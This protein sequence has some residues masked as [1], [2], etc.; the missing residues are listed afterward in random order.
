M[1]QLH[2]TLALA[3]LS[4][5]PILGAHQQWVKL[6]LSNKI[7]SD[8]PVAL[9]LAN[10]TLKWGHFYVCSDE[11]RQRIPAPTHLDLPNMNPN[12]PLTTIQLCMTGAKF[13]PTGVEGS[14]KVSV[15]NVDSKQ[16][17]YRAAVK[18]DSPAMKAKNIF[19]MDVSGEEKIKLTCK[20]DYNKRGGALGNIEC[21][22][23]G[24]IKEIEVV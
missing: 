15:V 4:L 1:L 24:R 7:P 3:L 14:M 13:S 11:K 22:I 17:I 12:E 5:T 10:I 8:Q 23:E 21:T 18:W 2:L 16:E 20:D 9:S 19:S 6:S